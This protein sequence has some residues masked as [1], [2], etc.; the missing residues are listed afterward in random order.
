M[1][2]LRPLRVRR[3]LVALPF[4]LL[5]RGLHHVNAAVTLRLHYGYTMCGTLCA[6]DEQYG[7]VMCRFKGY[8]MVALRVHYGYITVTGFL[9]DYLSI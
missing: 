9:H 3:L 8:I 6:T 4:H 7:H 2:L 5:H 1:L